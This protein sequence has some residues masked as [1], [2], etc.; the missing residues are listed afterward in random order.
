MEGTTRVARVVSAE[1]MA[2]SLGFESDPKKRN[3]GRLRATGWTE[4][5]NKLSDQTETKTQQQLRTARLTSQRNTNETQLRGQRE[6]SQVPFV[7]RVFYLGA[8]NYL[9]C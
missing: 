5:T 1:N 8:T 9:H 6:R 4:W 7:L 2:A 3:T